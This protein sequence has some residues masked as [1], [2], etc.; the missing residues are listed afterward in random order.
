MKVSICIPVYNVELYIERCLDSIVNQTYKDLEIIVVNDCTP[1]K[2]M[3]I[4]E[5]FAISDSR[6]RVLNHPKNLGLMSTRRTGYTSATGDYIMFCDSDDTLPHNAVETLLRVAN[7]EGADIVSGNHV[8]CSISNDCTLVSSSLKYGN[9]KLSIYRSLLKGEMVHNLWAKLYKSSLLKDFRYITYENFT[10][11]EDGC[12]FY[13]IIENVSKMVH[14]D[15]IVYNYMQNTESSTQKRLNDKAIKSICIL[16]RTRHEIISKY[17]VLNSDLQRYITNTLCSLF[18][19]GY[20][21]DTA[22]KEYIKVNNLN[23]YITLHKIIK[24]VDFKNILSIYKERLIKH[25]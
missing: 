16:N 24:N 6:I 23:E 7:E 21:K 4:V 22:L 20:N 25:S 17:S 12:L 19:E 18:A 14:V 3:D 8:Y 5:R 15:C 9:D 1:D 11:G 2:S 13:Q 10:N